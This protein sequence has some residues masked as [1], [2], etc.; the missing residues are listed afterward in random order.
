VK[1][2]EGQQKIKIVRTNRQ[3]NL[4][5]S[6]QSIFSLSRHGP[7]RQPLVKIGEGHKNVRSSQQSNLR[8]S[9]QSFFSLPRHLPSDD[10]GEWPEN[11]ILI[12]D[13]A[14]FHCPGTT[15]VM[16]V[17]VLVCLLNSF[18]GKRAPLGVFNVEKVARRR[19]RVWDYF[20]TSKCSW[21]RDFQVKIL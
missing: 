17:L 6:C 14:Y 9:C 3:S 8:G 19:L 7:T 20:N 11:Q 15:L 13:W 5:S 1:I 10:R 4:H 16:S 2:D 12:P 21:P 18:P